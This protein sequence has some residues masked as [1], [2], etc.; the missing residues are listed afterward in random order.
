MNTQ[1]EE[2]SDERA[3]GLVYAQLREMII[4]GELAPG[5][6]VS[7]AELARRLGLS[8]TPVREAVRQLQRDGL[9]QAAPNQRVRVAELNPADFELIY[10]SRILYETL[11]LGITFPRLT[12][13]DVAGLDRELRN[14]RQAVDE[15]DYQAWDTAHDR[16][17]DLLAVHAPSELKR[18]IA[19]FY[20]RSRRYRRRFESLDPRNWN[21]GD[22]A[23]ETILQAC[24]A[25]DEITA[26]QELARHI[27]GVS[28]THLIHFHPGYEP[29][30][31]RG[32]LR[33]VLGDTVGTW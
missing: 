14:M 11:A 3:G 27:A 30:M 17:H 8:R 15:V 12:D 18:Q 13:P 22:S 23:H 33:L 1:L 25:D 4:E 24:R 2:T 29:T 21:V 31:L 10:A 9:V 28:L 32:A 5:T 7:Q 16:F 20:D 26:V 6:T 19:P